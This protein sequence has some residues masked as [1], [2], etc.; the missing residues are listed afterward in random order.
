MAQKD[1]IALLQT[2]YVKVAKLCG[3]EVSEAVSKRSLLVADEHYSINRNMAHLAA[4]WH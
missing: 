1:A 4:L 3:I 2:L